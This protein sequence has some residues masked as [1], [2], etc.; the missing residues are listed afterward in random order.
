MIMQAKKN[1]VV[2]IDYE[3]FDLDGVLVDKT[4]QEPMIYLHGGYD[5]IFPLVEEALHEKNIG[6]KI[7]VVLEPEDAFGEYE[8]ELMRMEDKALFP[9]EV[10]VG[11]MFEADD[12]DTE[13][14]LIFRVTDIQDDKLV[15]DANHPLAGRAV[16]FAATIKAIRAATEEELLHGHVHGADGSHTH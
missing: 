4:D 6:D 14:T 7:E 11:M 5:G 3:M 10:E 13:E 16:R 8:A 12:P 15:V 2:S 1:T 9:A